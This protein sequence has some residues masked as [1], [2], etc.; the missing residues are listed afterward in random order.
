MVNDHGA[1]KFAKS[2][3][4]PVDVPLI[5]GGDP[6]TTY[7]DDPPCNGAFASPI[8]AHDLNG[9]PSTNSW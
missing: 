7:M 6:I 4:D 3:K 5:N 8:P 2:P 9:F 1:R